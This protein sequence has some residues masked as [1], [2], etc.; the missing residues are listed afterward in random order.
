MKKIKEMTE[1]EIRSI[2]K[3]TY[4]NL[5]EKEKEKLYEAQEV[6]Y[7]DEIRK[8]MFGGIWWFMYLWY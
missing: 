5:S 2:S 3:E 1:E 6:I 8:M 4:M 7:A